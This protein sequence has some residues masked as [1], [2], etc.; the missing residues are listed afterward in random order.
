MITKFAIMT[1]IIDPKTGE[2]IFVTT[3]DQKQRI[4]DGLE[5]I[6]RGEWISQDQVEADI[7]KWLD[8]S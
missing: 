7:D 1:T 3:T 6:E 2:L 5:Q 4:K 8:E